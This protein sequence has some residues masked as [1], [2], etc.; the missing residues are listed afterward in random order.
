MIGRASLLIKQINDFIVELQNIQN[1]ELDNKKNQLKIISETIRKL[2]KAGIE[3]PSDLVTIQNKLNTELNEFDNP[4]EVLFFVADEL[5]KSIEKIRKYGNYSG[6]TSMSYTYKGRI[7]RDIPTTSRKVLK[8]TLIDVLNELGGHGNLNLVQ[9]KM[10]IKLK[11]QLKPADLELLDDGVPRWQKN[12]QWLR[13]KLMG[14][15]VIKDNSPRGI[16]EL[17]AKYLRKN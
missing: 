13:Y 14:E 3:V 6:D 5:S 2:E 4:E 12:V 16:W 15:G 11:S 9:E 17:S 7:S 8:E 1:P 10:A